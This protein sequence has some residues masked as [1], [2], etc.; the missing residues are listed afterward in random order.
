M[1]RLIDFLAPLGVLATK[2]LAFYL[3]VIV[4]GLFLAH[5]SVESQRWRA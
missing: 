2:D 3:S 4:L 5:Q 1:K